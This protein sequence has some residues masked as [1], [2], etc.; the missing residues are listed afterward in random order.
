MSDL[1]IVLC[2]CPDLDVAEEI[3]KLLVEHQ[4]AACV[5]IINNVSSV[6]RWQ[7]EVMS[8]QEAQLVIKTC[9][10][11]VTAIYNVIADKHPYDTPE[12]LV[13]DNVSAS[14]DYLDWIKSSLK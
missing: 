10:K 9:E 1:R 6:Y 8:E 11:Q 7:N 5:N 12:W 3:A 2:T 4:L 14:K 13:L